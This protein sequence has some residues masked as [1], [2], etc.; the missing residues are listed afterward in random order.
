MEYS[1][2]S[3]AAI[4]AGSDVFEVFEDGELLINGETNTL[5]AGVVFERVQSIAKN[6]KGS[7]KRIIV[8]TFDLG[9]K[10]SIEVRVNTKVSML[11]V[12]VNG[13]YSTDSE[14]LL[15]ASPK[16]GKPLLA[17]DG[18]TDLT[19]HWNTFGE[20]WQVNDTTDPKLFHDMDRH[21]Q[22]P[23]NCI[24]ASNSNR[25]LL[26][27]SRRHLMAL[28]KTNFARPVS[29]DMATKACAHAKNEELKTFCVLDVMA[30]GDL[31]LAE[32]PFY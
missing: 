27:G 28:P 24:Y 25:S 14:G 8:Y 7:G 21:P 4:K 18:E 5:S 10:M 29:H 13:A 31:E 12:D 19:G 17:R 26:R 23:T 1:Y 2:I 20:E 16:A 6:N 11:F 9:N 15:G 32:D 22:Y 30:T 3:G